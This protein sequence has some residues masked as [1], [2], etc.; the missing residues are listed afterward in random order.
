MQKMDLAVIKNNLAGMIGK[1]VQLT[2][3]KIRKRMDIDVGVI[4]SVHPSIF[5][6]SVECNP[7]MGVHFPR[8]LSY[9]YADLLTQSV[10]LELLDQ[11]GVVE[12]VTDKSVTA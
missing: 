4:E 9:S 3:K 1:R 6:V 2:T 11:D 5:I 12:E 7:E 10:T 8:R